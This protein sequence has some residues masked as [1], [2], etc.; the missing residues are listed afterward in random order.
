MNIFDKHQIAIAKK[1]LKMHD[2]GASI[3]GGMSK[4]EARKI[5]QDFGWSELR[6]AKWENS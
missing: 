6:I 4:D 5:L 2:L 3:M 1:T